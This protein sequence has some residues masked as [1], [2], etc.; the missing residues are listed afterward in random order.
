M[1][2]SVYNVGRK[3][4][5]DDS[6]VLYL[7]AANPRSYPGSGDTWFDL[8]KYNNNGILTNGPVYN[9]INGGSIVFDGID[10]YIVV[11]HN[12]SLNLLETFTLSTW[13]FPTRNNSQDY[14]LNKNNIYAIIIGYQ[15]GYVNFYNN[16]YQP[17]PASTQIPINNNQW[18]NIV[19]SK[20]INSVSNNWNG[21]KNGSSVFSLSQNFTLGLNSDNLL[22]GSA[23]TYLNFFQGNIAITQIYNRAL[24]AQEI[25]QN[26][27]A[28]K[29][30]FG[31]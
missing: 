1:S 26:Y 11:N 5:N 13:I 28:T 22:I 6:L 29:G 14:I 31:L 15:P 12:T 27:N 2:Y 10:D 24:S 8:T 4:V 23:L 19:Y 3:I 30:R 25:Q 18:T 21:Y 7:D 20:N 9:N 16:G 17:S